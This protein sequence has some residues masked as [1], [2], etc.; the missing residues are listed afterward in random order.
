MSRTLT[1]LGP[2]EPQSHLQLP[3]FLSSVAAGFPSPAEDWIEEIMDLNDLLIKRPAATFLL[4]VQGDS[5]VRAGIFDNDIL[6]VDRSITAK[7][8]HVVIAAIDGE[9]TVKRLSREN[10]K[11]WLCPENP[12][13]Q[14]L[15]MDENVQIWGTVTSSIRRL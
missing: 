8:G 9:L 10:G 5:M 12:H 15:A 6:V 7:V 4:R 3:L 13:Y 1:I 14:P 2:V 11:L